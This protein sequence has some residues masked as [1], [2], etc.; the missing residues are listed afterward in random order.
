MQEKQEEKR[1]SRGFF[2]F[3]FVETPLI[4]SFAISLLTAGVL[5]FFL[6]PQPPKVIYSFDAQKFQ[7]DLIA[8]AGLSKEGLKNIDEI[9]L[10]LKEMLDAYARKDRTIVINRRAFIS[11]Y[12]PDV[13]IVDVT[14][15]VESE[16]FKKYLPVNPTKSRENLFRELLKGKGNKAE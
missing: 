9:T 12:L 5:F 4:L 2:G 16:L 7:H 13:K 10:K 14:Q 3:L 15:E 8:R 11:S 6:V 1:E